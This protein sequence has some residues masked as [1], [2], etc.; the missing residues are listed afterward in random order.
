PAAFVVLEALPLNPSGKVDRRALASLRGEPARRPL[1]AEEDR[2]EPRTPYEEAV[3]AIFESVLNVESVGIRDDFFEFG[4]HSLL[5]TQVASR[6]RAEL[7]VDLPLRAVFENPTVAALAREAEASVRAGRGLSLPPIVPVARGDEAPLSFTQEWMWFVDQLDPTGASPVSLLAVRLQGRLDGAALERALGEVTRRH[8]VL[9]TTFPVVGGR[10]VQKVAPPAPFVLPRVDLAALPEDARE[11]ESDALLAAEVRR[12]LDLEYGPLMRALLTAL[13]PEDHLLVLPLHH[14]L[15]DGW[16]M[17]LLTRELAALYAAFQRGEPSPLPPLP[18]QYA[19]F[20][21]W[22]RE[23]LLRGENLEALLAYWTERLAG[24]PP[25]LELPG[26][27]Q[28]EVAT[29]RSDR[30]PL[31]LGA[32]LSAA[33]RRLAREQG[34][35]L[36][37]ALL[38]AF[39]AL[40]C[41]TTRQTDIRVGSSIANRNG[42]EIEDLIG[43]FVNTL[44]MRGDLAGN[45]TFHGL[46]GQLKEVVLGAYAHQDLPFTRL[47]EALRPDRAAGRT[48]LFQVMLILQN[49]PVRPLEVPGAGL[50]LTPVESQVEIATFDLTLVLSEGEA[51]SG[52]LWFNRDLLDPA[53]AAHLG[54]RFRLLLEGAA[55]DP[56]KRLS[57][58]SLLTEA[59]RRQLLAGRR[60]EERAKEEG[61]EDT[62]RVRLERRVREDPDAVALAGGGG[63]LRPGARPGGGIRPVRGRSGSR[64]LAAPRKSGR[65]APLRR[66][67]RLG[68]APRQERPRRPGDLGRSA[69][70]RAAGGAG[71]AGARS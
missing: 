15:V 6:L 51:L 45:P 10:P 17:G 40:L 27:R 54:E 12:R 35:T 32:G 14:I 50:T 4:G 31:S 55:A 13:G 48:P 23:S 29:L 68:P 53:A 49:T 37:T 22:Q 1:T 63:A 59:E 38:A 71:R 16:S 30:V 44:V 57:E 34:V 20:A 43:Y 42:P 3:A 39:Q 62:L 25:A 8:E 69:P 26:A 33:A 21:V 5:A 47:V 19:D 18:V 70:R 41:R 24:D 2:A 52:W 46:L 56:G 9:R 61:R 11:A 64:D 7:A 65:G 67:R 28:G 60:A 36:Y 58:I 66:P